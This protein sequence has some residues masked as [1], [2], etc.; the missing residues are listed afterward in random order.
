MNIFGA[1]IYLEGQRA[2]DDL[3]GVPLPLPFE[4]PVGEGDL[5]NWLDLPWGL[6][7]GVEGVVPYAEGVLHPTFRGR[8]RVEVTMSSEEGIT[9]RLHIKTNVYPMY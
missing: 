7:L 6:R 2:T 8:V 1:E 3:F 4:H 5:L 9:L